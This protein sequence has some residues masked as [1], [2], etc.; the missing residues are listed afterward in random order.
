M[1]IQLNTVR[2]IGK[3]FGSITCFK[4]L[5]WVAL[6]LIPKPVVLGEEYWCFSRTLHRILLRNRL[7]C[8]C[9]MRNECVMKLSE[10]CCCR[11]PSYSMEDPSTGKYLT[12]S[13]GKAI[14]LLHL[15]DILKQFRYNM[16]VGHPHLCSFSWRA[17]LF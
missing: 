6:V 3:L 7:V 11:G 12:V 10:E 4:L 13:I 17:F 5:F 2:K 1:E 8:I 14:F 15:F 9:R 16:A